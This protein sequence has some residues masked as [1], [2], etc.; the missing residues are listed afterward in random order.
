MAN[1]RFSYD[2]IAI[3]DKCRKLLHLQHRC[4]FIYDQILTGENCIKFYFTGP[5][6][7]R[8]MDADTEEG[9]RTQ[10]NHLL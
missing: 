10:G 1:S 2:Y 8:A 6:K 4:E 5:L 3:K 7:I 9:M